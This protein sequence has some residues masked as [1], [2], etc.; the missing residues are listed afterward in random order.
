MAVSVNDLLAMGTGE[1]TTD[2]FIDGLFV[3]AAAAVTNKPSINTSVVTSPVP[4]ANKSLTETAIVSS[5]SDKSTANKMKHKA[6]PTKEAT[7]HNV[8]SKPTTGAASCPWN[9]VL[10]LLAH[11]RTK[12]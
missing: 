11:M 1:V 6:K 3:T 8:S 9:T 5:S 2:V 10:E 4:M 7:H 12:S